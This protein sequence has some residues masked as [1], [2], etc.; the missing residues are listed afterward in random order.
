MEMSV[1]IVLQLCKEDDIEFIIECRLLEIKK[2]AMKYLP[3]Y[4]DQ[5]Q[6]KTEKSFFSCNRSRENSFDLNSLC[7]MDWKNESES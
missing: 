3:E 4:H 6:R 7:G 5:G 2:G 1:N